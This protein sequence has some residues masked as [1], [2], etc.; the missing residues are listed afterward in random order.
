MCN[1][2][3]KILDNGEKKRI[4]STRLELWKDPEGQLLPMV[5][6]LVDIFGSIQNEFQGRRGKDE[7]ALEYTS[8]MSKKYR[9]LTRIQEEAN[10]GESDNEDKQNNKE[11]DTAAKDG[12][13]NGNAKQNRRRHCHSVTNISG[14]IKSNSSQSAKLKKDYE[15]YVLDFELQ[16]KH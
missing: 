13:V 9:K 4:D 6:R 14:L 12:Q 15:I 7:A 5:E 10:E 1:A 2:S 3:V 8:K 16:T 11:N